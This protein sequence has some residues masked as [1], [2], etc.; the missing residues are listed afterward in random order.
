VLDEALRSISHEHRETFLLVE[1]FGLSY[2][3]A[4]DVLVVATGTVKSRMFRARQAL[5]AAIA[6]DESVSGDAAEG[7]GHGRRR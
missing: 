4:A 6:E 3:E 5:C 2:Q 7:P 1:V